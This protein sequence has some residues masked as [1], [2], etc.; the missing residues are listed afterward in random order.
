MLKPKL[1]NLC[2]M[3]TWQGDDIT[4][5]TTMQKIQVAYYVKGTNS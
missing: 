3:Y 1:L 5:F 2:S 4:E